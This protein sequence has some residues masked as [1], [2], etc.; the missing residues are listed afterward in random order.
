MLL[1]RLQTITFT[2]FAGLFALASLLLLEGLTEGLM[3]WVT[4]GCPGC[5]DA[6]VAYPIDL[7]RWHGAGMARCSASSSPAP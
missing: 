2:F 5:P 3:P 6:G 7:M 1:Q 4:L